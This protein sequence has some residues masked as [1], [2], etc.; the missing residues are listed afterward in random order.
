MQK[1]YSCPFL[2]M[3]ILLSEAT[4]SLRYQT[5]MTGPCL[6][7]PNI[8]GLVQEAYEETVRKHVYCGFRGKE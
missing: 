8:T 2:K 6:H 7:I 3:S 1:G 5:G 4:L